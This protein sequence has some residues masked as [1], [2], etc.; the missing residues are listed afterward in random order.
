MEVNSVGCERNGRMSTHHQQ[1][2]NYVVK[3]DVIKK[4]VTND[5]T[6]PGEA[7]DVKH[8]SDVD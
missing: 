8:L 2:A 5:L 4:S 7:Y 1:I 3:N 6:E